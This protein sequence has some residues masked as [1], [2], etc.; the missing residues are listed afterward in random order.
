MNFLDVPLNQ[1]LK[2][3]P[4]A[5]SKGSSEGFSKGSKNSFGECLWHNFMDFID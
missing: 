1:E 3:L 4:K 5:F 2:V